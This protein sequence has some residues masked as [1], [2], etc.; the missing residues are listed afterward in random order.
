V[1]SLVAGVALQGRE[2][3]LI[4][5]IVPRTYEIKP[6]PPRGLSYARGIAARHGISYAQLAEQRKARQKQE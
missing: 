2:A 3:D 1:V 4:D 5:D 6:G